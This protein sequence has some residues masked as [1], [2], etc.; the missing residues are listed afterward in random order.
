MPAKF[1]QNLGRTLDARPDRLDLRDREFVPQVLSLPPRWPDGPEL[2]QDIERY[3]AAGLVLD[4]GEEGACTGFGLACVVN[5]LL[6][7]RANRPAPR[8][9]KIE[10]VSPRMLYHLARFYDEW[11]GEDYEGSSCRGALKAWHKHGVCRDALWPYRDRRGR[12][13]FIKPRDGWD[14]DAITR[15]LGVYYR[16]NRASVVDMQAALRQ[17]GA[18]FVAATVHDGWDL[19]ANNR[20]KK[21]A[22]RGAA[23]SRSIHESLPVIAK[24][25]DRKSLGG[26]AF[27]LVGYNPRG[28]VVQNSWGS[29]WG[30]GGFAM[31]PYEEWVKH[32]SDAWVC[33]L[34]VPAD[35][36]AKK[37]SPHT[38][39]PGAPRAVAIP[40][41]SIALA[42]KPLIAPAGLPTA[43]APL[44][45]ENAY[46][47]TLVWGNDGRFI[48]RLV[49]ARDVDAAVDEQ[50]LGHAAEWLRRK[51]DVAPKIVIY[52]HG[53][54]NSEDDSIRRIQALAPYFIANEIYPLFLTW[55][56]G[57]LE[58]LKDTIDDQLKRVPRPEGGVWDRF[59][60]AMADALDRSIEVIAGPVMKPIWSQM[61][62]NATASALPGHGGDVLVRALARLIERQPALEIH[63]LGHSAGSI[64]LGELL[65][66]CTTHQLRV[67]SC[68]LYAPACTLGFAN[69]HYAPA[70]A[71]GT[72]K[73]RGLH[74]VN[75]SAERELADTVGP[76]RKSLLWLVARALERSHKTPLLGLASALSTERLEELWHKDHRD[77]V[78]A[79]LEHWRKSGGEL[80][81]LNDAQV[82]TGSLGQAIKS[83]HGCFDNAADII[84]ASLARIRGAPL[85]QTVDWLEY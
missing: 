80:R 47:H 56:T 54:L 40:E 3:V 48:N 24:M 67:Q 30:A 44:S 43:V 34:G 10:S 38:F 70:L 73:S 27:A 18:L 33:A 62:Q 19:Q 63:L 8:V 23:R 42:A 4:Q 31:L 36:E 14:A 68:E 25:R 84:G 59:K 1:V 52:A 64:V 65:S 71:R 13:V 11:S 83:T 21:N 58:T 41:A 60:E 2:K 37:R 5:Y 85:L 22:S 17:V 79:W 26:H 49:T 77:D 39:K 55:K 16:V 32:G 45:S 20:D 82:S 12:V 76:Y 81:L 74:I 72:L 35:L 7:G 75:L 53:G 51:R 46:Q 15:T 78:G 69:E 61:K 29:R 6:F 66:A 9:G 28:F 57:P 50:V